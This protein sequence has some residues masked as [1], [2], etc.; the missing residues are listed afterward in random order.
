MSFARAFT[1]FSGAAIAIYLYGQRKEQ[2]NTVGTAASPMP[3]QTSPDHKLIS[4]PNS[5]KL[6][7]GIIGA[8]GKIGSEVLK[9]IWSN[10]EKFPNVEIAGTNTVPRVNFG[11]YLDFSIAYPE[12]MLNASKTTLSNNPDAIKDADV[13]FITAGLW[14]DKVTK[15]NW[16][17]KDSSGRLVQSAVNFPLIKKT[18]NDI[19]KYA[20]NA[21]VYVVT[22]QVDMMT[23]LARRELP[24]HR[25]LGIGGLIDSM[26][27]KLV[28]A[29]L[30]VEAGYFNIC[31]TSRISAHVI[32]F[33]NGDMQLLKDSLKIDGKSPNL[34]D[35]KLADLIDK[36]MEQTR[37][38]G[39]AISDLQ[40]HPKR[41]DIDSGSSITPAKAVTD[42]IQAMST[43]KPL[44]AAFNIA[45]DSNTAQHYGVTL[46]TGLSVP[47]VIQ[48][49]SITPMPP[50][51]FSISTAEKEKLKTAQ[52]KLN[53]DTNALFELH[54]NQTYL[55]D[56]VEDNTTITVN[57]PKVSLLP[58]LTATN[59]K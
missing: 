43:E 32:C 13:I 21:I 51:A 57:A 46:I 45:M 34:S 9:T 23:E 48:G 41:L 6:K 38:L 40:K 56:S 59:R 52:E 55:S 36:A 53:K 30:L 1:L 27:Y 42:V 28:L 33:H 17:S 18:C 7:V 16:D 25:V 24:K 5:R 29:N 37:P 2:N 58:S 14:P 8:S 39:K 35:Q 44:T 19:N 15:S 10:P 31:D 50:S 20:P 4:M 11:M 3:N 47:V 26:R 22:N 12:K 54:A 49:L